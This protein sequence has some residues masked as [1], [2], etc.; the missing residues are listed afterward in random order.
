MSEAQS[1]ESLN[2]EQAFKELQEL[3]QELEAGEQPLE[4]SLRLF[5]RGQGLAAR[6]N[7][8]LEQAELRLKQLVQDEAG[9]PYET[10]LEPESE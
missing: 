3:V 7:Q 2:F 10:D 4:E 8:L 1:L 9:D 6:C 5:E